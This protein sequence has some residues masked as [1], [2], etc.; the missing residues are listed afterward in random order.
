VRLLSAAVALV[1]CSS[2]LAGLAVARTWSDK[3]GEYEVEADLISFDDE[4]VVLRRADA[5][6]AAMEIAQ[7]SDADREYLKSQ[8][9]KDAK[10]KSLRAAQKW[11]LRNGQ[12][13]EGKIVDFADRDL[14]IDR[15]RGRIFVNDRLMN[16]LPEFYRQLVPHIV[17]QQE[18]LP[19]ATGR[20]LRTWLIAQGDKP[21]IFHV[22]GVVIEDAGGDEFAVPFFLF[23]DADLKLLQPGWDE[24]LAAHGKQDYE[25]E[26]DHGFLLRSLAA[27]R[28]QDHEVQREI[29]LMQ[30][31]MQTI[32]AG[33]TSL[34]EVT[35]YPAA[36]QGGPPLWVAVTGRNNIEATDAALRAHPG[37]VAGPV[38]RVSRR[39]R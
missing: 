18:K 25:A 31:T 16:N 14:T 4:F 12:T 7:L 13:I 11:T 38:R 29:A 26:D 33:V 5:E 21:H 28:Q 15:R 23:S 22:Q 39:T 3:S 2:H 34:W 20:A 8:E 1:V 17:A 30:L 9:A 35:L 10:A 19:A 37:Y 36:G 27:A 32:Q 6:L 24:W